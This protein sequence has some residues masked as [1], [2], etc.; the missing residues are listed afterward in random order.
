[1][2]FSYTQMFSLL[3]FCILRLFKLK[4]EGQTIYR[5]PH[6]KVAK[7]TTKYH[8][9]WISLI[10]LWTTRPKSPL[11]GLAKSIYY[12]FSSA[13][14][15]C[16]LSRESPLP[17]NTP[18]LFRALCRI[19]STWSTVSFSSTMTL[20]RLKRALLSWNEGFSVVAPISV[21]VPFSTCGRKVS[22]KIQS[23]SDVI[24]RLFNY[25]WL[26]WVGND[27]VLL[28]CSSLSVCGKETKPPC[29]KCHTFSSL[30]RFAIPSFMQLP[31]TN[32]IPWTGYHKSCMTLSAN[33]WFS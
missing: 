3:L 29:P 4:T 24:C 5:I 11:R 14:F 2:H 21:I 33:S 6:Y 17:T 18:I 27:A 13:R 7:I 22:Y 12:L 9:S 31:N 28:E 30:I 1:M 10:G 26:E 25:E 8:L 23:S 16:F 19:C 32:W 20:Q 15:L